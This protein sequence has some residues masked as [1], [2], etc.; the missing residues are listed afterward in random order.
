MLKRDIKITP[1]GVW[2]FKTG[3]KFG[4]IKPEE[5]EILE[6]IG[7]GAGGCVYKAKHLPSETLIV[8]KS[9]NVYEK[10]KRDQL[11]MELLSL[12]P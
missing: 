12:N 1:D 3:E 6:Q 8:L 9:I 4:F 11:S 7:I 10:E 2:N 5:I